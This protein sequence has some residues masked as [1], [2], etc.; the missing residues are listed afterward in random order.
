MK[1]F[2]SLLFA[3]L[4][5]CFNT[6]HAQDA[7]SLF[8][9]IQQNK[10]QVSLTLIRNDSVIAHLNEDKMMPLAST[11]KIMVAIEFAKQ[12]AFGVFD[13]AQMVSLKELNKY[14]IPLT[15]G[16]AHP[17][18]IDYERKNNHIKND[19]VS[20]V[21]IARGMI[22]FSSNANTEYLMDLLGL[23]NINSNYGLMGIR[24]FTPLYYSVSSLFL[25]QNPKR[26][27]EEKLLKEIGSL[28]DNNYLVGCTHI[29]EQLKNDPTY[30]SQFRINDL[31]IPMQ[32]AWSNRLPAATTSAYSRIGNI[33]NNRKI[34]SPKTFQILSRVLESLMENP[35]NQQWIVHAGMKGGSTM[36]VLTKSLYATLKNG[37]RIEL[38]YFFNDLEPSENIKIQKWMNGFELAVLANSGFQKKI[39]ALSE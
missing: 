9:F 35:A 34:F 36:F 13:T 8:N 31:T 30:K 7:D 5:Y 22:L 38:S 28:S 25:Y 4:V 24:T 32:R 14:Y 18:W 23:Q 1:Y 39:E 16:N 12:G 10:E 26:I 19:S 6:S 3:I 11:M 29:H 21:D 20:L 33:L 15:D 27:K 2:W 17:N 37:N